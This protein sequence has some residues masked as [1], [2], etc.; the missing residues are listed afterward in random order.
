ML[1]LPFVATKLYSVRDESG[2][3]NVRTAREAPL[4]GS[5]VRVKG[6]LDTVA[7]IGDQN[8]GLHL[9]EIERW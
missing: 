4:A 5:E 2:E 9:R 8:V 1:K 3:I 6:V 7:S